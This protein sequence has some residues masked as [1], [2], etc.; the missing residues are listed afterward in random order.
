MDGALWVQFKS[1]GR[2]GGKG[3]G[4][5]RAKTF[6]KE[7]LFGGGGT[8]GKSGGLEAQGKK[9]GK[10]RWAEK[11]KKKGPAQNHAS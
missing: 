9:G 2:G 11:K 3:W 10:V 1:R 7:V 4:E 8:T 6:F 5:A